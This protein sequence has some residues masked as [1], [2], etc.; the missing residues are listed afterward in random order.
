[1]R[2]GKCPR[3]PCNSAS[4]TKAAGAEPGGLMS[5]G[6]VCQSSDESTAVS[7]IAVIWGSSGSAWLIWTGMVRIMSIC[8]VASANRSARCSGVNGWVKFRMSII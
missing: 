1:M 4:K 8:V 2:D 5:K 3:R 6:R 7:T